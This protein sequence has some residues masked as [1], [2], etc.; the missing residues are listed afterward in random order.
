MI[1]KEATLGHI[2]GTADNI[3]GVLHDTHPQILIST[4]LTMTLHIEGNLLIEA[5]LLTHK[6]TADHTLN[7]P[8][9]QLRTPCIRIHHIPED[10]TVIYA[11]KEIQE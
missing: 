9:S 2:I 1:P 11:L 4:V 6:I 7:Q 3:T 10:P 5:H 8:T